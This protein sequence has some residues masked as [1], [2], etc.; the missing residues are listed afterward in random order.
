MFALFI[1]SQLSVFV[2]TPPLYLVLCRHIYIISPHISFVKGFLKI[3]AAFECNISELVFERLGLFGLF[4][5]KA[6]DEIE[7]QRSAVMLDMEDGIKVKILPD[8]S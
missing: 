8:F 3:I 7:L 4:E 6:R 2:F 5:E 1:K